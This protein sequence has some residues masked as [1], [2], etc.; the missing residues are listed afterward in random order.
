MHKGMWSQKKQDQVK[1]LQVA[2]YGRSIQGRRQ[3]MRLTR[4]VNRR[5]LNNYGRMKGSKVVGG[6]IGRGVQIMKT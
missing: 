1:K 5:L 3:L 6:W 4:L 2:L